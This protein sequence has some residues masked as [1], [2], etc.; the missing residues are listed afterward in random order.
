MLL[1]LK[2]FHIPVTHDPTKFTV[3]NPHLPLV[4]Q[5]LHGATDFAHDVIW[6]ALAT[7][8]QVPLGPPDPKVLG[9][10][11]VQFIQ[12][13]P[14]TRL[15]LGQ[16]EGHSFGVNLSG[17]VSR[18]IVQEA[19]WWTGGQ[20]EVFGLAHNATVVYDQVICNSKRILM[21][22]TVKDDRAK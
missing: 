7:D 15:R 16:Q 4:V 17:V 8:P 21:I 2:L 19:V 10:L 18:Q 11:G 12:R 13:V 14:G 6:S 20:I 22:S 1:L 3:Q 9:L 5:L